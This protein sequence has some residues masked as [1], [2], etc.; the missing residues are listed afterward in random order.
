MT[1]KPDYDHG[2]SRDPAFYE[3]LAILLDARWLI[4]GI[5]ATVTAFGVFYAMSLVHIYRADAMVQVEE[6]APQLPGLLELNQRL[7]GPASNQAIA[8]IEI[9]QSRSLAMS[10]AENHQLDIVVLPRYMPVVGQFLANRHNGEGLSP[11]RFGQDRF[12]W[13]GEQIEISRLEIADGT[14]QSFTLR[15]GEDG[16]FELLNTSGD[17]VF[18]GRVGEVASTANVT[19]FVESLVARAGTEFTVVKRSLASAGAAVRGGLSVV[20]KHGWGGMLQLSYEDPNPVRA[21]TV[22]NALIDDYVR[23]NVERRSEDAARMIEFINNQLPALRSQLDAAEGRLDEFRTRQGSVDLSAETRGVL[24]A[25]TQLQAR[26]N[27][28]ELER[29]QLLQRYTESHPA[30][31]AVDARIAQIRAEV[32]EVEQAIRAL[33]ELEREAL[34]LERDVRA[35][36]E[37]YML[38][39]GRGQELRIVRAGATGNIRV[40]DRALV[41]SFPVKPNRSFIAQL[42]ALIGLVLG[43]LVALVIKLS[44][45][46]VEDPV[47]IERQT[48]LPVYAVVMHSRRQLALQKRFSRPTLLAV[49]DPSDLAVEAIRGLRTALQFG[50]IEADN[51]IVA[52]SGPTASVGKSFVSVN[53]AA[54]VADSGKRTLLIDADLRRGQLHEYFGLDRDRGLSQVVAGEL[55][56]EAAIHKDA[57]PGVDF[58]ST[59]I[60]PPNPS[61]LLMHDHFSMLLRRASSLYDLVIIDVPPVL[62]VTDAIIVGRNAA[63]NFLLVRFGVTTMQEIRLAISRLTQT[64]ISPQGLIVNGMPAQIG[65]YGQ[66]KYG[67][68]YKYSYDS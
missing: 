39:L 55:E 26:L 51:N 14:T 19:I 36:N 52:I 16:R 53:L 56:L 60:I 3:V 4:L 18:V 35:A 54:V 38:L 7:S 17:P 6:N 63:V 31:V 37:L 2:E 61:E 8:E 66:Y 1:E 12:A 22:L 10:V 64:G 59:G 65:Y 20:E 34:A 29:L 45:R 46:G 42:S 23:E 21:A 28:Q 43:C 68:Q 11:A 67:Y 58:L 9:L 33:P 40:I 15:A 62:A 41:P 57:S 27:E 13:G 50:L 49:D 25:A 30:V 32:A 5:A 48:G 47:E 44:R 24:D